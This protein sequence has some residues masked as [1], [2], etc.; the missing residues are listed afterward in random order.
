M[1][2]VALLSGGKDSCFNMMHC[3]AQG[4]EMVALATLT[5]EQGIG[6]YEPVRCRM[7]NEQLTR[8]FCTR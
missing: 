6:E 5:P 3:V 1:K 4:H 8:H 2:V 7:L